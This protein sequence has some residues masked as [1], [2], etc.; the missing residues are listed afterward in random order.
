[1]P[2]SSFPVEMKSQTCAMD[3]ECAAIIHPARNHCI[4][5]VFNQT[6]ECIACSVYLIKNK[7]EYS[8]CQTGVSYVYKTENK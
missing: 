3:T 4:W 5:I 1:M 2:G 8:I 7:C 6:I